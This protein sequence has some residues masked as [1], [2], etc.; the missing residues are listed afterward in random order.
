VEDVRRHPLD[1]LLV[2][3]GALPDAEA[4]LLVDH[5]EA[6]PGEAD[7]RLDQRVGAKDQSQLAAG[8]LVQGLLANRRRRGAGQQRERDRLFGE[9]PAEGDRVLLGE[10]L[11]RRHQRR[12]VARFQRPQHRVDRDHGLAGADLPHQQALHR[13][14][15]V[16]VGLDLVERLQLIAG[17][18]ERQRFEPAADQVAGLAEAGRRTSRAVRPLA[19]RQQRLVE[20]QLFEA[21][22][23]AGFLDF[24]DR[25]REVDGAEG[26]A[27]P[28]EPPPHPH[29]PRQPL[30]RV[31]RQ[32]HR[33]LH[34]FADFLRG[35]VPGG[36]MKGDEALG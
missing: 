7:G 34:P 22:P 19:R 35:Q 2:E 8:E 23:F 28:R 5:A 27:D 31:R 1:P 30:D 29:L 24:F 25:L 9:E 11:R 3:R 17:R 12:L 6:E 32:R 26:I 13:L 36:G 18:L 4:V 20:K 10:R 14:A 16:E 33:P 15:G 21:E